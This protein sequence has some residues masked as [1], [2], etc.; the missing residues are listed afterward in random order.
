MEA[1]AFVDLAILSSNIN[2]VIRNG[3]LPDNLDLL[4]IFFILLDLLAPVTQFQ[5]SECAY[6]VTLLASSTPDVNA[7]SLLEEIGTCMTPLT[8]GVDAVT[9]VLV[10]SETP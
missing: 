6:N 10:E 5:A 2:G 1:D 9:E 7:T 8:E 3:Q 4:D